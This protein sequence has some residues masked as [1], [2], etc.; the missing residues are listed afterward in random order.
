[1]I[2]FISRHIGNT[3]N[4][5]QTGNLSKDFDKRSPLGRSYHHF[6]EI[7][8]LK[9]LFLF[10]WT[11]S[12][13]NRRGYQVGLIV[14]AQ[15]KNWNERYS[16]AVLWGFYWFKD[17]SKT[18]LICLIRFRLNSLQNELPMSSFTDYIFATNVPLSETCRLTI[19]QNV[20][21]ALF[22]RKQL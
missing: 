12:W 18:T 1:M 8:F 19:F 2:P 14:F 22:R 13:K 11:E 15:V 16:V 7:I 10:S 20:I 21:F 6:T 3:E 17:D 5:S 9:K 4:F